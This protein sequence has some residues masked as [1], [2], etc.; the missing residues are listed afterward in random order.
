M[1]SFVSK[2]EGKSSIL[3]RDTNGITSV[4]HSLLPVQLS[5]TP[6]RVFCTK[7]LGFRFCWTPWHTFSKETNTLSCF[8]NSDCYHRSLI[9]MLPPLKCLCTS[10]CLPDTSLSSFH[11][12]HS[13]LEMLQLTNHHNH[14]GLVFPE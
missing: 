14:G 10:P 6:V 9:V 1:L 11:Y 3:S 4:P 7:I 2:Q 12:T 5:D 8:S 13:L